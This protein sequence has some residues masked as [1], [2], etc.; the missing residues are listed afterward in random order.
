MDY[1]QFM[2]NAPEDC[3]PT[4]Y[5]PNSD[6]EKSKAKLEKEQKKRIREKLNQLCVGIDPEILQIGIMMAVY[7]IE[8]GAV[9]FAD[10]SK[11]M[12]ADLG[13][14][15]RPYLK[16][17]YNGVRDLPEAVDVGIDKS[18][19]PYDDVKSF[20]ITNFDKKGNTG[21][22]IKG[23][24]SERKALQET[25]KNVM[26]NRKEA[27]KQSSVNVTSEEKNVNYLSNDIGLLGKIDF[28]RSVQMDY[29]ELMMYA[30]ADCKP[31]GFNLNKDYQESKVKLAKELG[32]RVEDLTPLEK[33]KA[34]LRI[35]IVPELDL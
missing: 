23:V 28:K 7:H 3:K 34:L 5:K 32:K 29:N 21:I 25:G 20:D 2:S 33:D 27:E 24:S 1:K 10:F 8:R 31:T 16:S 9:K 4:V 14:K 17:F 13:D 35:G 26:K 19:T 12:I 18:M 11:A 22:D 6:Y 15:I 30:P